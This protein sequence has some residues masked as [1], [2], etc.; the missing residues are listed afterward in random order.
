MFMNFLGVTLIIILSILAIL[1]LATMVF[2]AII[3]A[4]DPEQKEDN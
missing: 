4:G 1:G 2:V 3:I